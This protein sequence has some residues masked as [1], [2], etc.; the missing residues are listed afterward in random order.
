MHMF[1]DTTS[2]IIFAVNYVNTE[3]FSGIFGR[4]FK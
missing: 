4:T 3:L 1:W 2:D